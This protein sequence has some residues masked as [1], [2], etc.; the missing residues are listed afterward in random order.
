MEVRRRPNRF[1]LN[2]K[3]A[4]S[5]EETHDS[6][7]HLNQAKGKFERMISRSAREPREFSRRQLENEAKGQEGE[8][9]ALLP[10]KPSASSSTQR[11]PI[12]WDGPFSSLTPYDLFATLQY[13]RFGSA[14]GNSKRREEE[15]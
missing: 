6:I 10:S 8:L 13:T 14:S 9:S 5:P 15:R 2:A 11:S 1:E 12:S 4:S 7:F 3:R